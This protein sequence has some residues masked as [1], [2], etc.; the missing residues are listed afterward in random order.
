M[1]QEIGWYNR[2][3]NTQNDRDLQPLSFQND[4]NLPKSRL[5]RDN[6][7]SVLKYKI[8]FDFKLKV[9]KNSNIYSLIY[10]SRKY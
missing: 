5:A 2:R 3:Y 1:N 9:L 6:V 4:S 8:F 10:K 7:S